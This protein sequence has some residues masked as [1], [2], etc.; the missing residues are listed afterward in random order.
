VPEAIPRKNLSNYPVRILRTQTEF[1]Q[2]ETK[3]KGNKA[4][5]GWAGELLQVKSG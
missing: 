1:A 5:Y 4:R 3:Q 2:V